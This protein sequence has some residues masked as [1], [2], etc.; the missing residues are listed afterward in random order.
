MD[1]QSSSK[2][3][4][5]LDVSAP[6]LS[7]RTAVRR[8]GVAL[9]V[10]GFAEEIAARY[11]PALLR[12]LGASP[13][14][15]GLLGTARDLCDALYAYP[16]GVLSDRRGPARALALVGL[17]SAVG[18]AITAAAPAWEIVV[19][20]SLLTMAWPAMGLPA[21]FDVVAKSRERGRLRAFSLQAV[22]RRVPMALGPL[23]GAALIARL[24][25]LRGT[26]IAMGVAAVIGVATVALVVPGLGGRGAFASGGGG[27]RA[28]EPLAPLATLRAMDRR[29]RALLACDVLSRL[30]EGIPDVLLV[31]YVVEV[32]G[33]NADLFG[34][35][36][37]VRTVVAML[38]YAP[39]VALAGRVSKRV[40]VTLGLT[41]FAA[42]PVVVAH[43]TSAWG[44]AV[45]FAVGGLREIGE[46]ARKTILVELA[47]DH[48]PHVGRTI[49]TYYL[50]RGVLVAGAGLAGG[51]L[52]EVSPTLPFHVAGAVGALGALAYLILAR[53]IDSGSPSSRKA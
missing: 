25:V 5:L 9:F 37:F 30:C 48:G 27:G 15:V 6:V 53:R 36:I 7:A 28:R 1:S 52:Y 51:F 23:F 32:A 41:A 22:L 26:R 21:T 44:L 4:S 49:G 19:A 47:I 13:A 11:L 3:P 50:V 14:G 29:M 40:F 2:E 42:F 31:L 46:P 8:S 20:A 17:A 38:S 35:L 43:A 34:P 39:A 12:G 45:A 18:Y 33:H 24:D 16:G 10:F